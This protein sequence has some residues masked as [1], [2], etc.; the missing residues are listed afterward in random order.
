MGAVWGQEGIK[1]MDESLA[2]FIL[3]GVQQQASPSFLLQL[4]IMPKESLR[5]QVI[6]LSTLPNFHKWNYV[7]IV[8]GTCTQPTVRYGAHLLFHPRQNEYVDGTIT[9]RFVPSSPRNRLMYFVDSGNVNT[10]MDTIALLISMQRGKEPMVGQ[11]DVDDNVDNVEAAPPKKRRKHAGAKLLKVNKVSLTVELG[12]DLDTQLN[13]QDPARRVYSKFSEQLVSDGLMQ[14]RYH[15]EDLDVVVL[16]DYDSTTGHLMPCS[17]VHVCSSKGDDGGILV[18]CTC[19]TYN[20]I[21]CTLLQKLNLLP[22]T[23]SVLDSSNTCMHGR[24][25][26]EHLLHFWND[27]ETQSQLTQLQHKIQ[28]SLHEDDPKIL[29]LGQAYPNGVTKFSVCGEDHEF[30]IVTISFRLG[31]CWA[32]CCNGVCAAKARN[33]KRIPTVISLQNTTTLGQLCSHL[34]VIYQNM[35]LLTECFPDFFLTDEDQPVDQDP[36][37]PDLAQ[38]PGNT[39]D[40][41]LTTAKDQPVFDVNTG[42]WQFPSYSQHKPRPM[43][44]PALIS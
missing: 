10:F 1:D 24:F 31:Q 35:E 21:Q 8:G 25:F 3:H 26:H 37:A 44:D 29:L 40:Q 4:P 30:A 23:E 17:F 22:G 16:N 2:N 19:Q 14:W 9:T 5:E 28:Y 38:D 12:L 42:L 32:R 41:G 13:C 15:T 36:P 20:L 7:K 11:P 33:K 39:D 43:L 27:M 34:V 6:V 18:R